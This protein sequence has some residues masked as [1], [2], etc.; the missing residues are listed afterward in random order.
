M[1]KIAQNSSV[2][3]VK[4]YTQGVLEKGGFIARLGRVLKNKWSGVVLVK[5]CYNSIRI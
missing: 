3:N 4:K 5:N 2:V 1:E